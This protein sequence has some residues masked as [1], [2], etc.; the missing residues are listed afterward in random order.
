MIYLDLD[1]VLADF[2]GGISTAI[3]EY[4]SGQKNISYSKTGPKKLRAYVEKWGTEYVAHTEESLQNREVKGMLYFVAAQKGF[5]KG[6][7]PLDTELLSVVRASG[8]PYTFLSGGIGTYAGRDKAWWVRNVLQD[9]SAVQ[10]VWG[11]KFVSTAEHKAK[12]CTGPD[13]LLIDD[14]VHNILEWE[15]AGGIA[16]LWTDDASHLSTAERLISSLKE[17]V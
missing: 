5:F 7:E 8:L 12:S 3:Y 6:L 16:L 17:R 13:D 2:V 9:D 1:G 14:T 15:N 11:N 4:A 10:V